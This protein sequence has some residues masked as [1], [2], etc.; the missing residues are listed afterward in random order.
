MKQ[1][2]SVQGLPNSFTLT[3]SLTELKFGTLT[4]TGRKH[5]LLALFFKMKWILFYLP[6]KSNA[7]AVEVDK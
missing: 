7:T 4:E 5:R 3:Y 1:L 6:V 2:T